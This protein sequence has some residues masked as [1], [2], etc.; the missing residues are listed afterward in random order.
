[1]KR[2]AIDEILNGD[3]H[4]PLPHGTLTATLKAARS[5]KLAGEPTYF[6]Q[7]KKRRY[8]K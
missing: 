4:K 1:M 7:P 5:Y 3:G 6:R 2:H 8:S